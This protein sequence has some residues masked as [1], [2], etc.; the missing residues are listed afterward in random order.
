MIRQRVENWEV[1]K[2]LLDGRG[3]FIIIK[4][5]YL[6]IYKIYTFIKFL[7]MELNEG[8]KQENNI[9]IPLAEYS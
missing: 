9:F 7:Q 3:V 6:Y 5:L 1:M 4:L 8:K 2:S